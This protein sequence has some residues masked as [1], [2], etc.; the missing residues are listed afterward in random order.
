ME[1]ALGTLKNQSSWLTS[2]INALPSWSS[3]SKS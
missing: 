3:S 1:T 2:Q